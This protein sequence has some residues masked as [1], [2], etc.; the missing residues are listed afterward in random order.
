MAVEDETPAGTAAGYPRGQ[1][2]DTGRGFEA[3]DLGRVDAAQESERDRRRRRDIARRVGR[4]R[5]D[6]LPGQFDQVA[7][8]CRDAA[9]DGGAW[10]GGLH[11]VQRLARRR[12]QMRIAIASG[13]QMKK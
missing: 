6:K 11:G 7:G 12:S 13:Q 5:G 1:V 8:R 3:L 4:R 9:D 10:V 2:D